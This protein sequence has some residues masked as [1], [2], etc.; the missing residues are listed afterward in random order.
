MRRMR[1]LHP[2]GLLIEPMRA[3]YLD[4]RYGSIDPAAK[5]GTRGEQAAARM[6]RQSGYV[7]LAQSESDRGG[8]LDIIAT[9]GKHQTLIFVE[10][11]TFASIKPGHPAERVDEN[12]QARV[13]RAAL[14]YLR[15]NN[16]LNCKCRF[17]VVAV[18]WPVG[19]PAP[20]RM[21]HYPHAFEATG[22][23]GFYS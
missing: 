19:V 18:W 11:K 12:K 16:L 14:R 22:V 1:L 13:T 3:R 15:R 5:L 6:L 2:F 7:I 4:W 8:E 9:D 21:E 20:T 23:N 10:V 17:D